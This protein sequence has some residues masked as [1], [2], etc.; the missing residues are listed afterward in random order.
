MESTSKENQPPIDIT[1]ILFCFSLCIFLSSLVYLSY[2]LTNTNRGAIAI[3]AGKTYLGPPN[4]Q[5]SWINPNAQMDIPAI[6]SDRSEFTIE[7]GTKW[8]VWENSTAPFRFSHPDTLILTGFSSPETESVGIEWNGKKASENILISSINLS[9]NPLYGPYIKK[10]KKEFVNF[11][12]QQFSGLTGVKTITEFTNKKGL[13]GYRAQFINTKGETPNTD[14]FF[15]IPTSPNRIIRI[16]NGILDQD[17][18]N[19]IVDSVEW[20]TSHEK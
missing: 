15:E 6:Q 16:A 11:W 1:L 2:H 10:P 7:P 18:F 3:P 12:W 5:P 13:K 19:K 20:K 14:I 8:R 17:V 9:I 4:T